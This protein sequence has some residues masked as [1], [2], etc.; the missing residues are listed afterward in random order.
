MAHAPSQQSPAKPR[1]TLREFLRANKPTLIW[2][3]AFVLLLLGNRMFLLR[4]F[5]IP[6]GSMTQTLA[7]GDHILVNELTGAALPLHRG[8]IVVFRDS[9]GWL[10]ESGTAG[11]FDPLAPAADWLNG[12]R[13]HTTTGPHLV[14]RIIGLPGDHVSCAGP[15]AHLLV[16]GRSI[17]EP[18]LSKESNCASDSGF[19]VTVPEGKLWV[20]GDNR[21]G[22]ADSRY[23]ITEPGRGFVPISD[24]MGTTIAVTWP[25]T[26]M[27]LLSDAGYK[28]FARVPEP[29]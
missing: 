18:Y 8:D 21:V 27:H 16:N 14:K 22:S 13:G 23:H 26:R 15:C 28:A 20:M 19:D 29:K 12:L 3:L 24:V 9:Q 7:I 17:R 6:S 10:G 25:V 1:R 2:L 11:Q 4:A 5:V